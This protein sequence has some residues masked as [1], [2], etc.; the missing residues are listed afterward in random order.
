MKKIFSQAACGLM[1]LLCLLNLSACGTDQTSAS[2]MMASSN[3]M[4]SAVPSSSAVLASPAAAKTAAAPAVSN[5]TKIKVH[6]IDVGQGDSEFL[7]LPNGQTMLIDAGIPE[8]GPNVVKYIKDL[9]HNKIDYLI[10]THPHADHIGGMT[11]VVNSFDIG[12]F[13]MPK[14]I[15]TTKVFTNLI[16]ALKSKNLGINV[17]KVG[18]SIL[19]TG[20]LDIEILAPVNITGD[21]LNQYSAVVKVTYGANKFLFMGDA[22][23][24]SEEQITADVSADVLK[25][26]HHG[27]NT[28]SSQAFLNKVHP[29]YAVI[30]VGKGN[31]YGHPTAATLSK[32]QGIGATIYRTDN[33]GTIIF[34]SDS[35]TITIDKKASSVKQQAPPAAAKKSSG[36]V[37]KKST[38]V[39]APATD[40]QSQTVYI[41]DTGTKYHTA[42]CRTLKKSKHAIS[43]KEAKEKGYTACGICHPPE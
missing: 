2:S 34:T 26:G 20:N 18:V 3:V 41:T 40:D 32:L 17:A 6:Y 43:L 14:K 15:T 25:V 4:S 35:K 38:T 7:E 29:K 21:D 22:G 16:S 19:K 24:P 9:G 11:D 10:A 1:T 31:S 39:V 8:Q 23:G 5:G 37:T 33:D 28:A 27:S 12:K 30:E 42:S 36:S 13:Y